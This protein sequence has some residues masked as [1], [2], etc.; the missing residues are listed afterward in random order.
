LNKP[1]WSKK[2]DE[3]VRHIALQCRPGMR[4][5]LAHWIEARPRFGRFVSAHQDKIRKKLTG[6]ADE[7]ARQDVR[8]ELLVS[9]VV[10]ADRRFEAVL[11]GYGAGN[12]GPD[13]TLTYREN[14]RFNIEVTR[15]RAASAA[16]EVARLANI[17]AA[18]VRQL[19]AD[20]PN[21]LVVVGRELAIL[22]ADLATAT[23]QLKMRAEIKDD[24]FFARR[25]LHDARTFA[26]YYVRLSAVFVLDEAS[27]S[28]TVLFW[29]NPQARR[30]VPAEA[31]SRLQ[32]CLGTTAELLAKPLEQG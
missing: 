12:V 16:D 19:A 24:A 28:R 14:Q 1:P 10:L 3:L 30:P 6:S 31:L 21:A 9:Y 27:A 2:T 26:T 20:L 17:I 22:E 11:E 5:E 7:E 8:A 18:K 32:A 23:R 13:L 25:G 29:A 15:L 4:I